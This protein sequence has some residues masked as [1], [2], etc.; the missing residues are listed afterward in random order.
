ML[1]SNLA[2]SCLGGANEAEVRLFLCSPNRMCVWQQ[3]QSH[4]VS[5]RIFKKRHERTPSLRAHFEIGSVNILI[6]PNAISSKQRLAAASVYSNT[7]IQKRPVFSFSVNLQ[8]DTFLH[9]D[10]NTSVGQTKKYQAAQSQLALCLQKLP[11]GLKA[12]V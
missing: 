2:S 12:P 11:L 6:A 5:T 10:S 3:L 1:L 7:S 4:S 9:C 8:E